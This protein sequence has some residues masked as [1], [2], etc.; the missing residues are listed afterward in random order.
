MQYDSISFSRMRNLSTTYDIDRALHSTMEKSVRA[1]YADRNAFGS[2]LDII[3]EHGW[4]GVL[5]GGALRDWVTVGENHPSRDYDIVLDVDD[6]DDLE[7]AFS[8]SIVRRT[9]FGGLRLQIKSQNFDL[10]PLRSTW[11]FRAHPARFVPS[12]EALPATT[13][14]DVDAVAISLNVADHRAY[15]VYSHGFYEAIRRRTIDVN[16]EPN[17][18]P[19]LCVIRS[20]V[21]ACQTGFR[22]GTSLRRYLCE[23]GTRFGAAEMEAIQSSHYGQ[24][25]VS[26]TRLG[27]WL[28]SIRQ[29]AEVIA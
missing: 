21:I 17:P 11:A 23:Q 29:G 2:V 7:T 25:V 19:E 10:W 4:Q 20:L 6:I 15:R 8:D 27:N 28:W 18:Y 5:F 24:I 9:R 12:F 14:L 16:F 1:A 13:F 22:L 3:R 26:P